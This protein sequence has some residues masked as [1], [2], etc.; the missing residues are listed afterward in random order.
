[1]SKFYDDATRWGGQ[2]VGQA[3]PMGAQDHGGFRENLELLW[4]W[5]ITRVEGFEAISGQQL[6][7]V[8]G[9]FQRSASVRLTRQEQAPPSRLR[10]ITYS[11]E[12]PIFQKPKMARCYEATLGV[13]H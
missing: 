8:T 11:R 13:A 12:E 3:C 4:N 6:F 9:I 5:K 7:D 2:Y 10:S 1:M